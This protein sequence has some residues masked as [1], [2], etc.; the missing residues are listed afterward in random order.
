MAFLPGCHLDLKTLHVGCEKPHAYFIPYETR[1]KAISDNRGTS[2]FFKTLCG[3]WD[4]RFYKSVSDVADFT[5]KEFSDEGMDKLTVPSNWQ[6][7]LY[8]G[9]G[10]DVPNYTNV[11]YPY[12][13]DPPHVPD[14]NPCGL[15]YRDFDL[16]ETTLRVK[17]VMLTFEGVDSCFYVWIND[18]YVGYSQ[19]S[20]MTSEFNVTPYCLAGRNT[21]KVLVIKW[22]DGSYLEDQDMWRMSGIFR[23]TYLLF[24]D[25]NR[26]NDIYVTPSVPESLD[27]AT[28][29]AKITG[30]QS[31]NWELI[32]A[33]CETVASGS[34]SDVSMT[35]DKPCLWSDETPYLYKLIINSGSE[36]IGIDVG[37]RRLEIKDGVVLIN[38]MKVKA[39]GVDRHDSHHLLGHATPVDHMLNDLYIMKQHNVNAIRTSHYPNDPRFTQY[40]D[41]LGFYVIDECDIETHGMGAINW[42]LLSDSDDW[43]ESYLDRI[44][45]LFE[46]DKNHPSVIM[47]SLGNE[48]GYGKNHVKMSEYLKARDPG[49]I[50]HYEGANKDYTGGIQQTAVVDI[51]SHM[52]PT[53]EWC[54]EYCENKTYRQPLFLCEYAHSMGN[55]PGG[56]KEYWETIYSHD[57]F[58]GGCVW[59]FIDHSVAVPQDD[60]SFHFTYG[61]DFGDEPNDGNFCVDGLVYPDRRISNSTREMK[62]AY[63]PFRAQLIDGEAGIVRIKNLN[64]F[65]K[66]DDCV[67]MWKL[68]SNGR[69]VKSGY[70]AASLYPQQ[71]KD[72]KLDY[73]ACPGYDYLT[74]TLV[75]AADRDVWGKAGDVVGFEQFEI[76]ASKPE[77]VKLATDYGA[78]QLWDDEKYIYVKKGESEYIFEKSLG[79]LVSMQQSGYELLEAPMRLTVWRAPT[80]NDRNIKWEWKKHGFDRADTKCYGISAERGAGTVVVKASIS[81]GAPAITPILKADIVY[82][83][84]SDGTLSVSTEADVAEKAPFLPR[85]GYELKLPQ[86]FE[87]L[88]WFGRGPGEAYADKKLAS[89]VGLFSSS[90]D[91][92]YEPYVMP[93]ENGSHCDTKWCE[94][95]HVGGMALYAGA[96]G[97]D[98][99]FTASHYST[100]ELDRAAHHYELVRS[101]NTFLN[102]DA[103]QS[104][105]GSNSCGPQLDPKWRLS[106]KHIAFTIRLKAAPSAD[107]DPWDE[108]RKS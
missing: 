79:Y 63:K 12:P 104:G 74:L 73:D 20:H 98:M 16:D 61:G 71:E 87:N 58:F 32:D 42:S 48:S 49:R 35:L 100:D 46:R 37:L 4:F 91:D 108:L 107:I 50:V 17:D 62:Q 27:S 84:W 99:A 14:E 72:F 43:T 64:C 68:E 106:A 96:C 70:L 11:N 51:E 83:I 13:V 1:E 78:P 7:G 92:Q 45:R 101:K 6:C 15:Y 95:K 34:L 85:L 52:Y 75:R 8:L 69:T 89:C 65:T 9:R 102:L 103:A 94:V 21:V 76:A 54:A 67:F 90:V 2:A 93:Q 105:I 26:V 56:F 55:G 40:C 81:L 10:Y 18:K 3:E 44:E 53:P 80:D 88:T 39:R 28:I 25:R 77:P 33:K 5:G 82:T 86:W 22:C 59:E 36:W 57:N 19:V 24:R 29:T 97:A 23:E 41:R 31:G 47:W 38:G 66:L 30:S 60:G